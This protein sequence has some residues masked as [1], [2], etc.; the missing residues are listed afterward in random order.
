[1]KTKTQ[2][3]LTVE[4]ALAQRRTA[5]RT[6]S[7]DLI[8]VPL[9]GVTGLLIA[10]SHVLALVFILIWAPPLIVMTC[11]DAARL[12]RANNDLYYAR[13]AERSG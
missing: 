13:Q 3:T 6:R 7:R 10:A 12:S 11:Y 9:V 4:E 8:G 5:L 2:R 1:M